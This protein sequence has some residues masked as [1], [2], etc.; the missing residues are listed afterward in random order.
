VISE[1]RTDPE[2][3]ALISL[4]EV[5]RQ[6]NEIEARKAGALE[7]IAAALEAKMNK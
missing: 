5:K 2:D 7:R 6:R 4:I 1:K 3:K